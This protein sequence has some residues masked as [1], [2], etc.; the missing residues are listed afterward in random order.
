MPPAARAQVIAPPAGPRVLLV[1]DDR[2]LASTLER[3]L[4]REGYAAE[5]VGR[6]D[7][8]LEQ[9][10]G[11]DYDVVV[12]DRL[13]PG[14]DGREVCRRLRARECWVPVLML[15]ALGEVE[16]RIEG[17]DAGADD[18]LVKPF[19]FGELL[20][21]LR[22]LVR[23]GPGVRPSLLRAGR[24]TA[25]P[26]TRRVRLDAA[27]VELTPREFALLAE[28]MR[29]PGAVVSRQDLLGHVWSAEFAGSSNVLDV[30][31]GY[32]RRKL[33]AGASVIRTIRG[34][35]FRLDAG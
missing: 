31:I 9:M 26:L 18:Y 32:L 4:R 1:E 14:L 12:L 24:L 33:P 17:L 20:A 11:C 34:R 10:V 8:A 27:E 13:L 21:R 19:D 28:L 5:A 2:R 16:D 22:V 25:D 29:R 35:G 30:Y 15:T 23:R 3:G 6:G 7:V